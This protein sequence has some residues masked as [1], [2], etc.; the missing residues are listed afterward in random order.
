MAL[1]RLGTN[2]IT[3]LPAG[4]GG[5]VLQVFHTNSSDDLTLSKDTFVDVTGLSVLTITPSSTSSKILCTY[6]SNYYANHTGTGLSTKLFYSTDG[7]SS[8]SQI[9]FPHQYAS[10]DNTGTDRRG[11]ANFTY[12]HSPASSSELKYKIQVAYSGG[13]SGTFTFG[14]GQDTTDFTIME[15]AG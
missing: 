7:G 9:H 10:H 12:L 4:I 14:N 13:G 11:T 15:I 3:A 1:T 8:Y 2:S 5:K 6:S